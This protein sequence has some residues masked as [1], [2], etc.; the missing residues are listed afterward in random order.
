MP[1]LGE[2]DALVHVGDQ[3]VRAAVAVQV[4][5][6][7]PQGLALLPGIPTSLQGNPAQQTPLAMD[8]GQPITTPE[9][10]LSLPPVFTVRH[11]QDAVFERWGD[12][13]LD[14]LAGNL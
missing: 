12:W 4:A 13:A 3:L 9:A 11:V 5:A 8:F 6:S 14:V 2:A 7:Q 10:I 1:A